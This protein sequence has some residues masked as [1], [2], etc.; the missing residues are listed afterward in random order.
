[1]ISSCGIHAISDVVRMMSEDEGN[2]DGRQQHDDSSTIP[3]IVEDFGTI[4]SGFQ[5]KIAISTT[6]EEF[7][8]DHKDDE[9]ALGSTHCAHSRM[10]KGLSPRICVFTVF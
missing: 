6:H 1:M 5:E 2:D 9:V 4:T 8:T 3:C 7:N 10:N